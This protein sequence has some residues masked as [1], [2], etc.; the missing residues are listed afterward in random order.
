MCPQGMGLAVLFGKGSVQYCAYIHTCMEDGDNDDEREEMG[1]IH[2]DITASHWGGDKM[3]AILH[4]AILNA[5]SQ[6][7]ITVFWLKCH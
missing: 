2:N 5:C 6:M 7:K 1:G 4:T 3:V